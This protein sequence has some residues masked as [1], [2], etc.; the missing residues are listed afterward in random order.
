MGTLHEDQRTYM[1][2]CHCIIYSEKRFRQNLL[3]KSQHTFC[4]RAV[5][6]IMWENMAQPVRPQA[7]V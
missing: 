2:I 7:T 4:V 6:E 3:R 1:L 5:Y